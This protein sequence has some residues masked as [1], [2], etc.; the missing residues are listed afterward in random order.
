MRLSTEKEIAIKKILDLPKDEVE[1]V[2]IFITGLNAGIQ[3]NNNQP[4]LNIPFKRKET[5]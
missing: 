4:D 3:I 1:K 5:A 2:L